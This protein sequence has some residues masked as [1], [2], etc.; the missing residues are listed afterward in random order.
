MDFPESGPGPE[1]SCNGE[2]T[3]VVQPPVRRPAHSPS[4]AP[5][6]TSPSPFSV[7][8]CR[9]FPENIS[10]MAFLAALLARSWVRPLNHQSRVLSHHCVLS[11][12]P[13]C[14]KAQRLDL[15]T[16]ASGAEF[17]RGNA[18]ELLGVSATSSFEEIKASFRKLAKETHPDLAESKDSSASQR[19][20]QILAAYEVLKSFTFSI[21]KH[22]MSCYDSDEMR[23]LRIK[24]V[25]THLS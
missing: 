12:H 18:Y 14:F 16:E 23:F 5:S 13:S 9:I 20:I 19:F 17:G 25:L 11:F 15:S 10:V 7:V 3:C 4:R 2:D 6:L 1:P 22:S 8:T 21:L 24:N